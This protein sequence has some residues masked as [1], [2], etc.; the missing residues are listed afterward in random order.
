MIADAAFYDSDAD[1]RRSE[2]GGAL[3]HGDR[4][5]GALEELARELEH[6]AE[7]LRVAPDPTA[8]A[9]EAH[10]QRLD[11]MSANLD[12][13]AAFLDRLDEQVDK[14]TQRPSFKELRERTGDEDRAEFSPVLASCGVVRW[15]RADGRRVMYRVRCWSR[16]CLLCGPLVAQRAVDAIPHGPLFA[17]QIERAVWRALQAKLTRLRQAGELGDYLRLPLSDGRLLIVSDAE[18]GPA[19]SRSQLVEL[20][21]EM[22]STEH[23]NLS[24]SR[25]WRPQHSAA[26]DGFVDEGLVTASVEHVVATAQRVGVTVGHDARNDRWTFGPCTPQQDAAL[27]RAAAPLRDADWWRG[28]A[29]PSGVALAQRALRARRAA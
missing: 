10:R 3:F 6:H 28:R 16:S 13:R 27:T 8:P 26:P 2:V 29:G 23:G 5:A 25:A 19:M 9:I 15:G 12:E 14:L 11:E 18:I 21:N 7:A 1:R 24:A 22:S 20:I 4:R 17:V